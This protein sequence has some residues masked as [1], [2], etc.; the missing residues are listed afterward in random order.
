MANSPVFPDAIV[1]PIAPDDALNAINA[2][3]LA[4]LNGPN[5][6]S[7]QFHDCCLAAC[8]P[9]N[10]SHMA[11]IHE[12]NPDF[13]L[14]VS[15]TQEGVQI[16]VHYPPMSSVETVR[17]K[18]HILHALQ[19]HI[20]SIARDLLLHGKLFRS[21]DSAEITNGVR[22]LIEHAGLLRATQAHGIPLHRITYWGGQRITDAEYDHSKETGYWSARKFQEITT[23]GGQGTMKGPHKGAIEGYSAQD[24]VGARRPG[25]TQPGIIANEP[26]HKHIDPLVTFPDMEKR[27][28]AFV[29][30]SVGI[31]I[32]PGG[33]GTLEEILYMV[34]LLLHPENS[35]Q[36][37]AIVLTGPEE[38][39]FRTILNCVEQ[40]LGSDVR[41]RLLERMSVTIGNPKA[42]CHALTEQIEKPGGVVDYRRA[43]NMSL[44]W[45]DTLVIPPDL[46]KPTQFSHEAAAQ[47]ELHREQEPWQLSAQVR[48][49]IDT[50]IWAHVTQEGFERV[51]D[52]P[53]MLRG[54]TRIL[55]AI[56]D[57]LR[58]LEEEGRVAYRNGPVKAVEF[59]PA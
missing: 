17:G 9:G 42:A 37:I 1:I 7:R 41:K 11:D 26:P 13:S 50:V 3:A 52:N 56:R 29:R 23:G 55:N 35:E 33:V 59:S 43:Q 14:E 15:R 6:L 36:R 58:Y 38:R 20:R 24:I 27:L 31:M 2:E 57:A 40:L 53:L 8:H 46:Q 34:T 45:N 30:S 48:R 22:T 47:L 25:F 28:E 51:R 12:Q 49:A 5:G 32:G 16:A 10:G 19:N 18:S 54:D 39:Y 21:Q 4:E 44:I